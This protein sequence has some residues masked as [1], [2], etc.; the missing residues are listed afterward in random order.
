MNLS[1]TRATWISAGAF[2]SLYVLS[3]WLFRPFLLK[4]VLIVP[5][6]VIGG[7]AL[8]AAI[9]LWLG[10]LLRRTSRRL[11]LKIFSVLGVF[12]CFSA[13][14]IPA[15]RWYYQWEEAQAMAFPETVSS[16][17]EAYRRANGAYPESLNQLDPEPWVPRLLR[18]AY[19]P[20]SN[21]P[22]RGPHADRPKGE[23]Y[24]FYFRPPAKR[25]GMWM[26]DSE[27]RT[28]HRSMS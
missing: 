14:A 26:Y 13:L 12:V 7:P 3:V 23:G 16:Q 20:Y 28:W 5:L 22:Y 2:L 15:N 4:I 18:D 10:A 11:A 21:R 19:R 1:T 9:A 25:A 6:I 8:I 17:L 27:T 24:S